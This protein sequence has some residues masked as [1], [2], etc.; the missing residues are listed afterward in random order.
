MPRRTSQFLPGV[1]QSSWRELD[2]VQQVE[3]EVIKRH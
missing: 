3:H 2:I 1:F